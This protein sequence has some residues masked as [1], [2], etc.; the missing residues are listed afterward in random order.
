[1]TTLLLIVMLAT[2][3]VL[4]AGI[5]LMGISP[6]LSEKYGNQLMFA[7]VALQAVAVFMIILFFANKR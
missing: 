6:R 1:M 5:V 4:I 7:R 2:L 3:A